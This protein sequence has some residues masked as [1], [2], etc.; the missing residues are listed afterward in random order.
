MKRR[1]FAVLACLCL[2]LPLLRAQ[3]PKA[4]ALPRLAVLPL[5]E[6]GERKLCDVSDTMNTLVANAFL[7]SHA[8]RLVERHQV[9]T[10]LSE[11]K[12]QHSG[13]V[14]ETTIAEMGAHLGVR[15]VL[16]GSFLPEKDPRTGN[17]V[18]TLS[19]R[20]VDVENATVYKSFQEIAEGSTLGGVLARLTTS[21]SERTSTL[22]PRDVTGQG[23]PR[24]RKALLVLR[25][26]SVTC[27]KQAQTHADPAS[28][29]FFNEKPADYE[30]LQ[31]EVGK[32]FPADTKIVLN[33]TG[34]GAMAALVDRE[35][36]DA[37]VVI[38]FDRTGK[39]HTFSQESEHR[40]EVRVEFLNPR[41]LNITG[42]R[43]VSTDL[44]KGKLYEVFPE[45]KA[46]LI[47][48]LPGAMNPLPVTF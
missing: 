45:L 47:A 30:F 2:A 13:L 41:N 19:L 5:K 3:E 44:V 27:A 40:V 10:L 32:L 48:R 6:E 18:V 29:S 11:A 17:L 23:A 16:V 35:K 7:E 4:E 46:Q 34:P 14:D 12:F 38:T 36:P 21:L 43:M 15:Y 24:V 42:A 26:G 39:L 25:V 1:F 20:L 8:F 33:T 28:L 37:L 22:V 31:T 9:Q